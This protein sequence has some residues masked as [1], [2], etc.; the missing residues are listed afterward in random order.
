[1]Q[2]LAAPNLS[3]VIMRKLFL[4]NFFA[5]S[6]T[7]SG[8]VAL[9]RNIDCKDEMWVVK[10]YENSC[11]LTQLARRCAQIFKKFT[12][13]QQLQN[14]KQSSVLKR[15]SI[16]RLIKYNIQI[17]EH[18]WISHDLW[19]IPEHK[20]LTVFLL[21]HVGWGCEKI[22]NITESHV[23]HSISFVQHQILDLK[24][25]ETQILTKLLIT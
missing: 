12:N 16:F 18:I 9:K 11:K 17:I 24:A 22:N 13:I 5:I 8:N 15:F 23:Q 21:L 6:C 14:F 4:N 7:E 20:C 3:I 10:K 1:M 2:R 25:T 19:N